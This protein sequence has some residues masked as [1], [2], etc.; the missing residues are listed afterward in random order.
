M[1]LR[2]VG[3]C[4]LFYDARKAR[5]E[6]GWTARSADDTLADTFRWLAWLGHLKRPIAE[7]VAAR[8]PPDPTWVR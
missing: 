1:G 7:S 3:G 4:S 6:L 8:F 5:E 2:D